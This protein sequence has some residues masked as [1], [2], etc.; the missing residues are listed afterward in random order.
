MK[1]WSQIKNVAPHTNVGVQREHFTVTVSDKGIVLE[2]FV[3]FLKYDI[4]AQIQAKSMYLIVEC[5]K[6]V[7]FNIRT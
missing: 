1:I 3:V 5:Q 6:P 7:N 4:A 2:E